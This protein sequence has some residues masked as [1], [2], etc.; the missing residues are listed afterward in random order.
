MQ[1]NRRKCCITIFAGSSMGVP[2]VLL[3][4]NFSA[5]DNR[6]G[7]KYIRGGQESC[8]HCFSSFSGTRSYQTCAWTTLNCIKDMALVDLEASEDIDFYHNVEDDYVDVFYKPDSLQFSIE[9]STITL[10]LEDLMAAGSS[11]KLNEHR[12][13]NRKCDYIVTTNTT[14]PRKN[15]HIHLYR[16]CPRYDVYKCTIIQVRLKAFIT[17]C[18]G[19]FRENPDK[20]LQIEAF[21]EEENLNG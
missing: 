13:L 12:Y 14:E 19:L 2:T 15:M 11:L 18:K 4:M 17:M 3:Q 8:G 20:L 1:L 10:I 5:T 6:S 21:S 7:G 9:I 16:K